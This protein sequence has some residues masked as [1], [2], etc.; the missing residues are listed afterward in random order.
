VLPC[1]SLPPSSTAQFLKKVVNNASLIETILSQADKKNA[2][3][4]N[5]QNAK[6]TA[7]KI[8]GIPKLDDANLAGTKHGHECTLILTEGD[9]AKALAVS[10][11]AVVGRDRFGVYPL[12][13]K[14]CTCVHVDSAG[15]CC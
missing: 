6:R 8:R 14:V 13:G 12:R 7:G 10:G 11:L 1:L 3:A 5:K 15:W 9:S 2:N 4:L